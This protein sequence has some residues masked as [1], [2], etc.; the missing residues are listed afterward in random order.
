MA[1]SHLHDPAVPGG[2]SPIYVLADRY[3]DASCELDPIRATAIGV[4]GHEDRL[5]DHSPEGIEA[6]AELD[7]TTLAELEVLEPR[8]DDDRV[9]AAFLRDRLRITVELADRDEHLR[10]VRNI[11]SP[12]QGIRQ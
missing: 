4:P 7:R 11:A 6:R 3:V 2:L 8:D 5:T 12:V 1:A 10:A 9:A